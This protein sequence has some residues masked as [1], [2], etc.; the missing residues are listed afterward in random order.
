LHRQIPS[1]TFH[2]AASGL[3]LGEP[4]EAVCQKIRRLGL[5]VVE[6]KKFFSSTTSLELTFPQEL[7]SVEELA[8]F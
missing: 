7:P 8:L 1:L 4:E 6:H 2:L 5:E 3:R